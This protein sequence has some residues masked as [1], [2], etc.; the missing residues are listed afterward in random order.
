MDI[1]S[2]RRLKIFQRVLVFSAVFLEACSS[3]LWMHYYDTRPRLMDIR[4]GRT[5]PL[6]THGI[7][8]YLTNSEHFRLQTLMIIGGACFLVAI[9]IEIVKT[10]GG[11]LRPNSG[12]MTPYK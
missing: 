12:S 3:A 2:A 8:V 4:V 9:L 7:V 5:V 10:R 6:N 1:R 11:F